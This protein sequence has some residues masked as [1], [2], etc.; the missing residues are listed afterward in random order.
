VC[1]C[2]RARIYIYTHTH[3]YIILINILH[4]TVSTGTK[5][6]DQVNVPG[7]EV[8]LGQRLTRS[9]KNEGGVRNGYCLTPMLSNL[10]SEY[11]TKKAFEGFGNSK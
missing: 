10:Y 11:L 9:V 5:K 4:E 6:I 8:R 7:T 1:V 2:V 3:I